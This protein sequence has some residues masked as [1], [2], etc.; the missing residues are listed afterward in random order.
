MDIVAKHQPA[1]L[2][3]SESTS[4]DSQPVLQ[5]SKWYE[6]VETLLPSTVQGCY[7]QNV[8]SIEE[9]LK[10]KQMFVMLTTEDS[11]LLE[12]NLDIYIYQDYFLLKKY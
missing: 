3:M 10:R 5:S 6:L 1:L 2:L 12:G 7:D 9:K 11:D 4:V 8:L